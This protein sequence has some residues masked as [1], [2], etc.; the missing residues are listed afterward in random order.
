MTMVV[1]R[2]ASPSALCRSVKLEALI[3]AEA[4]VQSGE[5]MGTANHGTQR[6]H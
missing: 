6:A 2:R 4:L 1:K 5:G 3:Q